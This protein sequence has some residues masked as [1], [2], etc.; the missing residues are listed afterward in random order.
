VK[1]VGNVSFSRFW[2]VLL[3]RFDDTKVGLP[4]GGGHAQV[5]VNAL[6]RFAYFQKNGIF[7]QGQKEREAD[8]IA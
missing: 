3:A 2:A 6:R 1:K 8:G 5:C 7:R 4:P